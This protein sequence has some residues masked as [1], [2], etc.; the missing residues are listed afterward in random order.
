MSFEGVVEAFSREIISGWVSHIDAGTRTFPDVRLH[1][2]TLGSF[3]PTD[4]VDRGDRTGF[5]FRLPSTFH[6]MKWPEFLDDFDAVIATSLD[7]PESGQWRVPL[8]KSVLAPLNPDNRTG[9]LAARLRDY[10]VRP[11]PTGR[12]AALTIAYNER[13]MLPL[14]AKYYAAEFGAENLFVIDQGS[15]QEYGDLLPKGVN[16]IRVPRDMFDNWLIARQV[17]IMQRFLLESY[18]SVL[19]SDSDEFVCA[20][21]GTLEGRSLA[22]HLTSLDAAIG[23]TTGYDLLHDIATEAPYDATRRLLSQRHVMRRQPMMDKPLIS[24]LPLN[25]VPG[26]HNAAEGGVRIPGLYLLHLRW[27]DLDQALIKGGFYRTSNWSTFDVEHKL[28]D[29]QREG[30]NEIVSRFRTNSAIAAELRGATFDP[31]ASHTVVPGW[32]RSAVTI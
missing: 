2:R 4:T 21:P 10:Q 3:V 18:D 17:A 23:I 20:E 19:Y 29:Y 14:W 22:G 1:F 25:W 16:I 9:L 24:R 12:I 13:V 6:D 28:A 31:A 7:H 8:Y 11:K 26:F 32:M 15:D 27:F 5:V 30:E